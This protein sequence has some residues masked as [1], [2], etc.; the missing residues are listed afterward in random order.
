MTSESSETPSAT[1][2][3]ALTSAEEALEVL[4]D[5]VVD[6]VVTDVKL[7]GMSGYELL[8]LLHGRWPRLPVI[9]ITGGYEAVREE[10]FFEAGAAGY[11]LKPFT[12]REAAEL[13]GRVLRTGAE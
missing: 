7:P 4:A 10:D 9:I 5:H 11:L 8:Q 1:F 3:K 2:S 12:G 13:I 6:A